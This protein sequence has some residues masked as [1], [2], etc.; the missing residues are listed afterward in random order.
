MTVSKAGMYQIAIDVLKTMVPKQNS[1]I[2]WYF[3]GSFDNHIGY[4][5][6]V[7]IEMGK[8]SSMSQ[9]WFKVSDN[10]INDGNRIRGTYYFPIGSLLGLMS[11]L[12]NA[13]KK[14][15]IGEASQL[16]GPVNITGMQYFW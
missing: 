11:L 13:A 8:N 15:S 12:L 16:C 3:F 9:I 14:S 7:P 4:A 1:V 10:D 6:Q 2:Y 5:I